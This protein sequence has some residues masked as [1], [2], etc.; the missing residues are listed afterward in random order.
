MSSQIAVLDSP[1]RLILSR[2]A[3]TAL[4]LHTGSRIEVII[5]QGK[6]TLRPLDQ[7]LQHPASEGASSFGASEEVLSQRK[8]EAKIEVDRIAAELRAMFAGEPSL[9][10]EYFSLRDPDKW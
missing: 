8:H 10:D 4:D 2:E 5:E 1:D 6:V 9:E 7:K 3:Q